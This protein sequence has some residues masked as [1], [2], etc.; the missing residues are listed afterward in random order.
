MLSF[1]LLFFLKSDS[2]WKKSIF[3]HNSSY[4]P[5]PPMFYL[6]KINNSFI[7]QDLFDYNETLLNMKNIIN[8]LN[9]GRNISQNLN[10]IFN[11]CEKENNTIACIAAGRIYE[12]GS[13][14]VSQN[15]SLSYDF[16]RKVNEKASINFLNRYYNNH[17]LNENVETG[18]IENL[19]LIENELYQNF[20]GN[21][22]CENAHLLLDIAKAVSRMIKYK[23]QDNYDIQNE[24]SG[25]SLQKHALNILSK[26]YLSE[27]E[28][29]EAADL[30]NKSI[31]IGHYESLS[32]YVKLHLEGYIKYN[33]ISSMIKLLDKPIKLK[34][35]VAELLLSEYYS[36]NDPS[37]SSPKLSL[38]LLNDAASHNYPEA[39]HRLATFKRYGLMG[40]SSNTHKAFELNQKAAFMGYLPSMY[41]IAKCYIYGIGV[42]RNCQKGL[43]I[44]QN[45]LDLSPWSIIFNNYVSNDSKHSFLKMIDLH[46]SPS[47]IIDVNCNEN[48][49]ACNIS[50]YLSNYRSENKI[51]KISNKANSGDGPSILYMALNTPFEESIYW[52][53]KLKSMP[54]MFSL[55]T[56]PVKYCILLKNFKLFIRKELS[57]QIFLHY[58]QLIQPLITSLITLVTFICLLFFIYIRVSL[59]DNK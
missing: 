19:R 27:N 47:K 7:I 13:Y 31:S 35:P 44:I 21:D 38:K 56:I 58:K 24:T 40:L 18:V 51:L 16:Y 17:T 50:K 48:S 12:F 9:D 22:T 3:M 1:F 14:N 36:L 34:D 2:P 20:H 4:L 15:I 42:K 52:L 43:Q 57:P 59:S 45:I 23:I 29:N 6:E 39:I 10:M 32:H 26:P 37:C 49:F 46:L 25:Y 28:I 55:F 33:N 8:E 30:L 53:F 11:S 41:K 54:P 5:I